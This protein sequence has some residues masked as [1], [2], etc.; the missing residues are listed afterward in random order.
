MTGFV[1][2]VWCR[3]CVDDPDGCFGGGFE[4]WDRNGSDFMDDL[5]PFQTQDEAEDFALG[6]IDG[7]PW[8]FEIIAAT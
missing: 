1:I 7:A 3:D 2:H 6:R 4:T 5:S 8:D